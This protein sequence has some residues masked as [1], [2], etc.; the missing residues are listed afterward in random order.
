MKIVVFQTNKTGCYEYC[1]DCTDFPD[2][3]HPPVGYGECSAKAIGRLFQKIHIKERQNPGIYFQYLKNSPFSLVIDETNKL[4]A[5]PNNTVC[6]E[7]W[8]VN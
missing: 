4:H 1:A 5:F 6:G 2:E 7:R 8:V 3:S